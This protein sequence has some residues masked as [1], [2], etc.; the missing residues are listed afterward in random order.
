VP[1][2]PREERAEDQARQHLV[3]VPRRLAFL[4]LLACGAGSLL[5]DLTLSAR[6]PYDADWAELAAALRAQAQPGDALQLWPVWAEEARLHVDAMPVL[7][8]E[9]LA[10]ADY[11]GVRRLWVASLPRTPHAGNP[12]LPLLRRGA[13][14]IGPARPFGALALRAWDLHAT[15][16]FALTPQNEEHEVDYVA[17]RCLP[18]RI[19]ARF[20]ARGG[21]GAML[22]VRAGII[23]EHAYDAGRPSVIVRAFAD[24]A[25]LGDLEVPRTER[26]GTG[27]RRLDV[28]LAK[29]PP[30][31]DFSFAVESRD[32]ARPLCLQAWISR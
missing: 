31:R 1:L 21:P 20:N 27:W 19:G 13:T 26:D 32:A 8:E 6:L 24:G 22:H 2:L 14:P 29:G 30:Q 3:S 16:T 28:A 4:A 5:F 15:D 10:G 25:A 9:D 18:V 17:R 7:A 11:L 23:G 12:E